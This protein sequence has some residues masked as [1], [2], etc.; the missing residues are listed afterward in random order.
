[1]IT[2][3]I[4]SLLPLA[5][6]LFIRAQGL[7]VLC[8]SRKARVWNEL[9]VV[10]IKA[11]VSIQAAPAVGSE[12]VRL[13]TQSRTTS[14]WCAG[15]TMFPLLPA[16]EATEEAA[17]MHRPSLWRTGVETASS[18]LSFGGRKGEGRRRVEKCAVLYLTLSVVNNA[19]QVERGQ[20]HRQALLLRL[21]CIK[22]WGTS[23]ASPSSLWEWT[24]DSPDEVQSGKRLHFCSSVWIKAFP[25]RLI[26]FLLYCR[27][28]LIR[29]LPLTFEL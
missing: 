26:Y 16:R 1:M 28:N 7:S 17:R 18:D 13:I 23:T 6:S 10:F 21:F 29:L 15:H 9:Q 25:F 4:K 27:G 5:L 14:I 12:K 22:I 11:C 19:A 20:G 24:M 2:S 8:T 3:F